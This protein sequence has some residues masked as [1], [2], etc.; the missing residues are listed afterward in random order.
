MVLVTLSVTF[1][2][3]IV[4]DQHKDDDDQ[5]G[6]KTASKSPGKRVQSSQKKSQSKR[7]GGTEKDKRNMGP[8]DTVVDNVFGTISKFRH[9]KL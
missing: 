6:I 3:T 9:G 1:Q 8:I 2:S 4:L 5:D 7:K